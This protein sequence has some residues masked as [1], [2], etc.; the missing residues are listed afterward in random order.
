L[1]VDATKMHINF[2]TLG[3]DLNQMKKQFAIGHSPNQSDWKE[4]Y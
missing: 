2:E 1:K 3:L 4:N